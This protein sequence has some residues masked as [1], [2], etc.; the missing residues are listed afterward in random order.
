MAT[1][2]SSKNKSVSS[3]SK[4]LSSVS[5]QAKS[6]GINTSKADAMVAQTK[7]QG[8]KSFSGSSFETDYNAGKY[9]A[10]VITPDSLKTVPTPNIPTQ[11]P[12]SFKDPF[13]ISS[14][15]ALQN[16]GFKVENNQYTYD[17]KISESEN[18]VAESNQ[19]QAQNMQSYIN[20]MLGVKPTSLENDYAK[21]EKQAGIKNLQNEVGNYTSQLNS[22]VAN[23]DANLLRVEGQGRGIPDVIIGGQQAQIQKEAAIQALPVQAALDAAQGNLAMAQQRVDKLF[24]IHREDVQNDFNFKKGLIDSVYQFANQSEQSALT[25]KLTSIKEQTAEKNQNITM[26]Q[27]WAQIAMQNGQNNLIQAFTSL[28]P[29]SPTFVQDLGR[30]QAQVVDQESA[31]NR[32]A[33][34]ASINTEYLQQQN[35]RDQIR[36]R[37]ESD[38]LSALSKID[39]ASTV[40]QAVVAKN[41]AGFNIHQLVNTLSGETGMSGAVGFS[42]QKMFGKFSPLGVPQGTKAADYTTGVNQLKD[43]LALPNLEKLKGAMSDKDIQFLRNIGT[44]LDTSM[45]EKAFTKELENIKTTMEPLARTHIDSLPVGATFVKDGVTF[46]KD[47]PNE[48]TQ[49]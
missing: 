20:N 7:S 21:L 5:K 11:Q 22:I 23:R 41:E 3:L 48:Y 49:I 4:K 31:L 29:K 40:D 30:L 9:G 33:K 10:P 27:Q 17:P 13:N 16:L 47:G 1:K 19:K 12:P 34:R 44:R 2:S 38:A 24:S 45:S 15:P 18:A 39:E 25:A 32:E 6:L 36:S 28:N 26:M 35:I 8:S 37:Q 42:F 14:T 43:M 46:R